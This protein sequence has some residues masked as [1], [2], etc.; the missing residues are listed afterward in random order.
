[1]KLDR[2]PAQTGH[3]A[4]QQEVATRTPGDPTVRGGPGAVVR[5]IQED[6]R[7]RAGRGRRVLVGRLF[8]LDQDSVPRCKG[9][10]ETRNPRTL[11]PRALG[12]SDQPITRVHLGARNL[13]FVIAVDDGASRAD[14]FA[15]KVFAALDEFYKPSVCG[16]LPPVDRTVDPARDEF[17]EESG[18]LKS[19]LYQE[20]RSERQG[21]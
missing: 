18:G 7:H 2:A 14:Q 15:L 1:M 4:R 5:L 6:L 13:V 16:G 20:R 17:R 3:V 21:R 9:R 19:Q 12:R 11:A 8:G 10:A